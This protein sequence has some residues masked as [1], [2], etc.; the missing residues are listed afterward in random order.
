MFVVTF[1]W[2]QGKWVFFHNIFHKKNWNDLL[3]LT[4]NIDIG[5][6]YTDGNV[7]PISGLHSI[8]F[9]QQ[10]IKSDSFIKLPVF[11]EGGKH[12]LHN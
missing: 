6:R 3:S 7:L 2:F 1:I 12:C 10:E 11:K 4:Y 9:Q 8:Y 5:C